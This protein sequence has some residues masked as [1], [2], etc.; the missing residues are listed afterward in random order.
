[1]TRKRTGWANSP[2]AHVVQ[3]EGSDGVTE[4]DVYQS[5]ISSARPGV[6]RV[7]VISQLPDTVI[8]SD[9][10]TMDACGGLLLIDASSAMKSL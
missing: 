9:L 10:H 7:R 5:E 2:T 6:Y 1:M 3:L 4:L 8:T